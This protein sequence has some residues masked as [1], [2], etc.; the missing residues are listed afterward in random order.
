MGAYCQ[1]GS[2]NMKQKLQVISAVN[3]VDASNPA[4]GVSAE[5]PR[6]TA[7]L[8]EDFFYPFS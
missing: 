1:P 2:D 8:P 5:K 6:V 3:F 4:M 7:S